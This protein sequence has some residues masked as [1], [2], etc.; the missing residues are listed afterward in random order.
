MKVGKTQPQLLTMVK[1][2]PSIPIMGTNAVTRGPVSA[3]VAT[4]VQAL[5]KSRGLSQQQLAEGLT[6]IGRPTL[7]TTIAKIEK[8]DRRVDVD[9]LVALCLVL[10]VSPARLLVGD[11][12]QDEGVSLTS[13]VSVPVWRAWQWATGQHSLFV[14]DDDLNNPDHVRHEQAWASERP[15][16]VRRRQDH[17][18]HRAASRL[19]IRVEQAVGQLAEGRGGRPSAKVTNLIAGQVRGALGA[20]ARE[21]DVIEEEATDGKY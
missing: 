16:W 14:E 8:G 12:D 17:D 15:F 5:R 4:S 19:M 1:M 11:G 18:L 13:E 6:A 10:N 20:V 9:D 2:F 3:T 21:V 7:T